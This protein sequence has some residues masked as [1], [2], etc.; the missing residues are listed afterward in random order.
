MTKREIQAE[1]YQSPCRCRECQKTTP[2]PFPVFTVC[3]HCRN[4]RCPHAENHIYE[5]HGSNEPDQIAVTA[6]D[7]AVTKMQR[8]ERDLADLR[9]RHGDNLKFI[10]TLV[11]EKA[12]AWKR[13]KEF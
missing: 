8:L 4:K 11:S 10:D 9:K 3:E 5:C 2:P 13:I 1:A 12:V 7:G 6:R